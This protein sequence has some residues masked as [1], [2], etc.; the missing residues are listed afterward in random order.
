[1]EV[2][3]PG[4]SS[5]KRAKTEPAYSRGDKMNELGEMLVAALSDLNEMDEDG[6]DE[7]MV[8]A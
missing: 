7:M 8:K 3:D 1:M 4:P 6:M 2:I 5:P